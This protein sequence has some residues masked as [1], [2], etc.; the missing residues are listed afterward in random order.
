MQ[1]FLKREF[2]QRKTHVAIADGGGGVDSIYAF[3]VRVIRM[4]WSTGEYV[5]TEGEFGAA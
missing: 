2:G 4:P 3:N 1:N 5:D